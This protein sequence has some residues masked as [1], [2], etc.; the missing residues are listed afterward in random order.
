MKLRKI[1]CILS[2]S[3]LLLLAG[4]SREPAE[5]VTWYTKEQ[6]RTF[7]G[8]QTTRDVYEYNEDWSTGSIT[9]YVDDAL[10]STIT[11]EH[12]ET[13]YIT[14][15]VGQD[16]AEETME[17]IVTRD[18][19]GNAIRTEQY[20]N[21]QLSSVSESTFDE[22]GN[23]LTFNTHVL[24]PDL[25]LRTETEYDADGKKLR[26]TTD[27]GYAVTT[28][29]YTYDSKGRLVKEIGT[30]SPAWTEYTYAKNDTVQTASFYD[31]NGN[32]SG[33]QV[34]TYDPYGNALLRESF[35]ANGE[36]TITMAFSYISTDGRTSS[37]I[38]G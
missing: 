9:T 31:E 33:T 11:Y 30:D 17:V 1:L 38:A 35:D 4:C 22:N 8:T 27:N 12:T 19:A 23:R 14:H 21:G 29:E 20:V 13:G 10:K 7:F 32:L 36:V 16:G 2:A 34:T 24:E 28:I 3:L 18:D 6:V 37:G 5:E 26:E 25:Y 15:G